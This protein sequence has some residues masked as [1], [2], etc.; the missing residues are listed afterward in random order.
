MGDYSVF[1]WDLPPGTTAGALADFC[2]CPGGAASVIIFCDEEDLPMGGAGVMYDSAPSARAAVARLNGTYMGER[3]LRCAF[4]PTPGTGGRL[5]PRRRRT[6]RSRGASEE[7]R[8]TAGTSEVED[9]RRV[10]PPPAAQGGHAAESPAEVA[11]GKLK[12][13]K[14]KPARKETRRSRSAS[15]PPVS[16]AGAAE[17]ISEADV[18][19]GNE[20]G[21][22]QGIET[23]TVVT[24]SSTSLLI[25]RLPRRTEREELAEFF[26][27]IGPVQQALMLP[28][29]RA[30]VVF[31]AGTHFAQLPQLL[32]GELLCGRRAR[33]K[34]RS[35]EVGQKVRATVIYIAN[36]GALCSV[37]W[38]MRGLVHRTRMQD[39]PT[40]NAAEVVQVGDE[41]SVWVVHP[42]RA[43][44]GF[45][46]GLSMS[47]IKFVQALQSTAP[48]DSDSDVGPAP[49]SAG[50]G[51][52]RSPSPKILVKRRWGS[53]VAVRCSEAART[54]S[55]LP[56]RAPAQQAWTDWRA[57]S[58]QWWLR[59]LASTGEYMKYMDV[60]TERFSSVGQVVDFY[61]RPGPRGRRALDTA[62]F[63]VELDVR[64]LG[65][66]RRFERWFAEL[67][68]GGEPG[69]SPRAPRAAQRS[70][71]AGEDD[72]ERV[73]A[74]AAGDVDAVTDDRGGPGTARGATRSARGAHA[75]AAPSS[76]RLTSFQ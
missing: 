12:K 28:G 16:D 49:A 11:C 21:S 17:G 74:E 50:E 37:S 60:L 63:L 40:R 42:P 15:R 66:A 39:G 69:G 24:E 35:L 52:E 8:T 10:C 20:L 72:W 53:A 47:W 27:R 67:G 5:V 18:A 43:E 4:V 68:D 64:S 22:L 70:R 3:R 45:R 51:R 38:G 14:K 46:L 29:C 56:Q 65:H 25:A 1:F 2:G 54:T 13:K 44:N 34:L 41:V 32:R 59:S 76:Q 61:T 33:V 31:A 23:L 26:A 9:Y 48:P 36:Y 71:A 6:P 19:G 7:S 73:D 57:W 30:R 75:P 55:Q 62:R 58:L